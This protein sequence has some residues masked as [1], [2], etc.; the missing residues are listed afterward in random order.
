ME[1]PLSSLNIEENRLNDLKS[2]G[3]HYLTNKDSLKKYFEDEEFKN[4]TKPPKT[5]TAF[6]LYI[7]QSNFGTI[8]TFLPGLDSILS[9]EI[10]SGNI[11]ELYGE[12]GSGK[13]QICLRLCVNVQ[14][15]TLFGGRDGESLY[16]CTNYNFSKSRVEE[17]AL[18]T[19]NRFNNAGLSDFNLTIKEML[20][21]ITHIQ[22]NHYAE[23]IAVVIHLKRLLKTK[24]IR[25]IIIDSLTILAEE[26][27]FED[28]R[29]FLFTLLSDL[30]KLGDQHGFAIILT[31]NITLGNESKEITKIPALGDN[32]FHRINSRIELKRVSNN[33]YK[34]TLIKSCVNAKKDNYF[35]I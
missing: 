13:T 32:F 9:E 3:Y 34:A 33:N 4:I 31:N 5:K 1:Q 20:S 15:P 30:Q 22:L 16:I 25:L 35:N 23:L 14:L 10:V 19:I 28:R 12:S 29:G 17:I 6:D 21:K 7:E 24:K 8:F 11:I 26:I 18:E 27:N 2:L